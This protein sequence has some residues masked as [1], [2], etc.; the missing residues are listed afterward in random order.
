M[1]R[2]NDC[3]YRGYYAKWRSA[4]WRG[5]SF[6]RTEIVMERSWNLMVAMTTTRFQDRKS[7][8]NRAQVPAVAGPQER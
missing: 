3:A 7:G 8:A 1:P 2:N 5:A 4:K 6:P